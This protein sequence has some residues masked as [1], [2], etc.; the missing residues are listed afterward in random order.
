M[1][2]ESEDF[3]MFC[4]AVLGGGGGGGGAVGPQDFPNF[5][6]LFHTTMIIKVFHLFHVYF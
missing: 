3:V 2:I 5:H 1:R 6:I 4:R